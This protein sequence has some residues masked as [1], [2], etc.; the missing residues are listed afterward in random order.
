MKKGLLLTTLLSSIALASTAKAVEI[1]S[2]SY[3]EQKEAIDFEVSYDGCGKHE[4]QLE[5]GDCFESSPAF[6][7]ARLNDLTEGDYCDAIL[8]QKISISLKEAGLDSDRYSGA[9]I[10][11]LDSRGK[12]ITIRLPLK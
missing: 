1:K 5:V 3:N 9:G 6:C 11:I 8:S 7:E 12:A 4:F 10:K 2:A